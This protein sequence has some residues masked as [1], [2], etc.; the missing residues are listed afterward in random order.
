VKWATSTHELGFSFVGV[1]GDANY[2]PFIWLAS[3]FNIPWYV[4]SDG[5]TRAVEQLYGQ[6]K[7]A[8]F[9]DP[10]SLKNVVTVP[11][12]N[13]YEA[14]LLAEGYQDA[15]EKGIAK[16]FSVSHLDSYIA[17]L[18]GKPGKHFDGKPSTRAYSGN[19]GRT[20]AVLD[21]MRENK[22][23][24]A[25]PIAQEISQ[26]ADQARRCP[27]CIGRLLDSLSA[28]FFLK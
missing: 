25:T 19:G 20:R 6:L 22:T 21:L 15:V 4:F 8:R 3:N 12:G 16:A 10:S 27:A 24:L 5:E 23:R 9:G 26:L 2:Y 1:G 11:N 18:D 14:E 28:D 13:D 17:D 7:R